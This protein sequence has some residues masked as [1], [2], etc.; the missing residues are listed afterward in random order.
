MTI[1]RGFNGGNDMFFSLVKLE[2]PKKLSYGN[3]IRFH[4]KYHIFTYEEYKVGF[5]KEIIRKL[6]ERKEL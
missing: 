3:H 6:H 1:L 4:T 2:I 5:E